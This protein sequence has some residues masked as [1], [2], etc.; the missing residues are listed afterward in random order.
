MKERAKTAIESFKSATGV[1]VEVLFII[2]GIIVLFVLGFIIF[3]LTFGESGHRKKFFSAAKHKGINEE[4]ANFLYSLA[5]KLNKDPFLV[6][7]FKSSFEKIIH[8]YVNSVEEYNEELLKTLRKKLGFDKVPKFSPLTTTKDIDIL[9]KAR[10]TIL[11][12]MLVL[13]GI[14]SDKD[15]KYMYWHLIDIDRIHPE[16]LDSDVE[17]M[18][19]REDDAIYKFESRVD[20]IYMDNGKVILKVPHVLQLSRIQRRRH[21]RVNVSLAGKLGFLEL[22]EGNIEK[23]RWIDGEVVNLSAGGIKFCVNKDVQ[24]PEKNIKE[25]VAKF[26]L[27][28]ITITGKVKIV[29]EN[30]EG[31]MKCLGLQFTE[32]SSKYEELIHDFVRKKQIEMKKIMD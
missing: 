28:N 10:I 1:S 26:K 25:I 17:V 29:R 2:L 27:E 16:F 18:F 30:I 14:L 32:I 9:Q 8:H 20:A 3:K 11:K 5:H 22:L 7:K 15:E 19:I 23:M 4:E 24:F 6:L 31:E 13:E 12:N 21:A